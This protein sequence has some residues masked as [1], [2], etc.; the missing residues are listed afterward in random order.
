MTWSDEFSAPTGSRMC[1]ACDSR[2][3]RRCWRRE[4]DSASHALL[5]GIAG[6][7]GR[8]LRGWLRVVC[9]EGSGPSAGCIRRSRSAGT[10]VQHDCTRTRPVTAP[11]ASA[12]VPRATT[13]P[14]MYCISPWYWVARGWRPCSVDREGG[15]RGVNRRRSVLRVPRMQAGGSR[16]PGSWPC[17]TPLGHSMC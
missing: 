13:V 3:I 1:S 9:S 6:A 4:P 17:T 12:S 16:S 15:R 10:A 2:Q 7:A 5:C 14:T 8:Q 11:M